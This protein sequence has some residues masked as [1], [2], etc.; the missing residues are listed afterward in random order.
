MNEKIP[1]LFNLKVG[2]KITNGVYE[3]IWLGT[4]MG[5][6]GCWVLGDENHNK[7]MKILGKHED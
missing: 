6:K 4:M 3:F 1:P 2:Q 5:T 7:Y